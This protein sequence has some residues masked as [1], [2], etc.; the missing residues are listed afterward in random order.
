MN[1]G[2][3]NTLSLLLA[4]QVPLGQGGNQIISFTGFPKLDNIINLI[5]YK[6][7]EIFNY[8]Y[9]YLFENVPQSVKNQSP[10]IPK[11]VA[12]GEILINALV[13]VA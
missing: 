4:I 12:I 11:S 10:F 1:E 5:K 9:K 2:Y 7:L 3:S 13:S 8:L 6:T